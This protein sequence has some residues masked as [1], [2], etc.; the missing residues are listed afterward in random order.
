MLACVT[1]DYSPP[2][3][4]AAAA[5]SLQAN[6]HPRCLLPSADLGAAAELPEHGENARLAPGWLLNALCVNWG[7]LRGNARGK[8]LIS[9]AV[10]S[11]CF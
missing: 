7:R 4:P 11:L 3:A 1:W 2:F 5:K 10:R 6:P 8:M 9:Y